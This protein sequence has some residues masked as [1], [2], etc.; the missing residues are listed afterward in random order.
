MA[1]PAAEPVRSSLKSIR[2]RLAAEEKTRK[3]YRLRVVVKPSEDATP[4]PFYKVDISIPEADGRPSRAF[5]FAQMTEATV[6]DE[7]DPLKSH[8]VEKVGAYDRLSESEVSALRAR[9]EDY[10]VEW[11]S[12]PLGI[13]LVVDTRTARFALNADIHEPVEPWLSIEGPLQ[14]KP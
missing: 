11:K 8:R 14:E 3:W 5:T 13:A 12:R 10:V 2:A 1:A 4:A 6:P 7:R 9:I